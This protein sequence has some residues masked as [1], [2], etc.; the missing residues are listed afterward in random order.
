MATR[1]ASSAD[2]PPP[3]SKLIKPHSTF[4]AEIKERLKEAK[5]LAETPIQSPDQLSKFEEERW[6]WS[7]YNSE[8]LRRS[9]DRADNEYAESYRLDSQNDFLGSYAAR[10]FI[11]KVSV[12]KKNLQYQVTNLERLVKKLPLIESIISDSLGQDKANSRQT[13]DN[14]SVFIVHG[15]DNELKISVARFV[16]RLG[17]RAVILHEQVSQGKT[18]IE[19]LEKHGDVGFAIIL[20][21]ADDKA[22][23]KDSTTYEARARQNVVLELG[24][25]IG[26]L[27]RDR[28]CPLIAPGVVQPSDILGIVYLPIDPNGRWEMELAKELKAAGLA[29]DLN[30]L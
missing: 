25:F 21:T 4:D 18:V 14:Q 16:E 30:R 24:Y 2:S 19:K 5:N 13:A 23:V 15:H 10:T 8:L 22:A 12:A 26:R 28:V 3:A 20:M 29:A 17:L 9:F 6:S 27:G 11:D 1:K 7:D